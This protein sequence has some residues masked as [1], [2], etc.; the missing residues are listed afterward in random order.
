MWET[1]LKTHTQKQGSGEYSVKN[2]N[3]YSSGKAMCFWQIARNSLHVLHF[4]SHVG[5]EQLLLFA[6]VEARKDPITVVF[7]RSPMIVRSGKFSVSEQTKKL[8]PNRAKNLFVTIIRKPTYSQ[9]FWLYK[10]SFRLL[11]DHLSPYKWP[12]HAWS[13]LTI[14][15]RGVVLSNQRLS[16][17]KHWHSSEPSPWKNNSNLESHL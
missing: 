14:I 2:E 16:R 4:F 11:S 10:Y 17:A 6:V 1:G 12:V 8:K 5:H 15:E 3:K 7:P 13:V 9:H